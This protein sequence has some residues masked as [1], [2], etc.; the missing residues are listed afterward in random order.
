MQNKYMKPKELIEKFLP[1]LVKIFD[2]SQLDDLKTDIEEND[3]LNPI[4]L[5]KD[6]FVLDGMRRTMVAYKLSME[7][8]PVVVTDMD[9]TPENRIALNN[10]R[11]MTWKDLR[12][13]YILLFTLFAKRQ[14]KRSNKY[15]DRYDEIAKRIKNRFSGKE[16]LA[17]IEFILTNDIEGF[18]MSRWLFERNC[19]VKSIKEFMTLMLSGGHDEIVDRVVQME[20]SPKDA[21]KIINAEVAVENAKMRAFSIPD[22]KGTAAVIHHGEPAEILAQIKK[23]S[24]QTLFYYPDRYVLTV[25][26]EESHYPR[27]I[28]QEPK[29]YGIKTAD[30]VRPWV[31]RIPKSGSLYV[32]T[33]EYYDDGFALQIP[34]NI[35]SAI[36]EETGL[37][38]KQTLF[39]A[40]G[41]LL[42]DEKASKN[43]SDSV[44]QILWFV[45]DRKEANGVFNPPTFPDK[46]EGTIGESE[47]YKSCSNF[48][49]EQAISDIIINKGMQFDAKDA[50]NYAALIPILIATKEDDL[51]VDI[52]MKNDIGSLALM[53]NRRFIGI[54]PSTTSFDKEAKALNKAVKE[55]SGKVE[56]KE[57]GKP[58]GKKKQPEMVA[59]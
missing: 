25:N 28:R 59:D 48:L 24:V 26:N 37:I 10:F 16:T 36:T 49:S 56:P 55:F 27:T 3:I 47:S 4:I 32:F 50:P 51:I 41:Q 12:N 54:S 5:S 39:V 40:N 14:G 20:L 30:P 58:K 13:L 52:S 8:V 35:I 46:K 17:S 7:S 45:K 22:S 34:A 42:T 19:D 31:D 18:P 57:D 21:M 2:I 1:E 38:F 33:Q 23:E 53:M 29:V 43:L 6:E 15:F 11:E 44:T 9:A